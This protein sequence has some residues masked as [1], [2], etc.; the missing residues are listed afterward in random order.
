MQDSHGLAA[1]LRA[2]LRFCVRSPLTS[3]TVILTL[4][5]GIGASTAV[6]SLVNAVLLKPLPV[7]NADRLVSIRAKT[8]GMFTYPEYLDAT[9]T[10]GLSAADRR[11]PHHECHA[12]GRPGAATRHGRHRLGELLRSA[13]GP[14][15]RA[16]P[17]ARRERRR[18]WRRPGGGRQ[19]RLLARR[20]RVRRRRRG[21]A[22]APQ[23]CP[24]HHR[25][26]CSER[27]CRQHP[28]F[29]PDLWIPVTSAPEME[30][31]PAMLGARLRPGSRC[32]ASS[33]GRNRLPPPA[34]P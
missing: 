21:V 15:G 13:R 24:V 20:A 29:A 7:A 27:L 16:R 9:R 23:P 28:G 6:F 3:A 22:A 25:R 5:I 2:A 11:R 18:G 8:G 17:S 33:S 31:N 19:P 4:T 26:D 10:A 1:D 14:A 30:G 12:G 32:S 34:P